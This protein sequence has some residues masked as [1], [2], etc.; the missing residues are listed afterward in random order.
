MWATPSRYVVAWQPSPLGQVT[1]P[2]EGP[3][4]KRVDRGGHRN[5]LGP[6]REGRM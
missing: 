1:Q 4:M 6:Q 3:G 2:R 5:Q